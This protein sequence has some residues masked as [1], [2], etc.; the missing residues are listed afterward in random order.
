MLGF[1]ISPFPKALG[2]T[3]KIAVVLALTTVILAA[4]SDLRPRLRAASRSPEGA[5]NRAVA[6]QSA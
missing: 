5:A 3:W 6:S 4:T 1:W 2:S